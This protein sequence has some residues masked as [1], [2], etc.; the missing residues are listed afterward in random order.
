MIQLLTIIPTQLLPALGIP[1]VELFPDLCLGWWTPP[2]LNLDEYNRRS[3]LRIL[4]QIIAWYPVSQTIATDPADSSEHLC[5][6]Y[7]GLYCFGVVS[8]LSENYYIAR[9]W[10]VAA[11]RPRRVCGHMVMPKQINL[12]EM[13]TDQNKKI[14][15][16]K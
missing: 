7:F 10:I 4:L 5:T 11:P 9:V 3:F 6:F 16:L 1:L 2:S 14:K 15:S 8:V 12:P 13:N